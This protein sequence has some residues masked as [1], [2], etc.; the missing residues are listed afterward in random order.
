M[1]SR[2]R[3]AVIIGAIVGASIL[4]FCG[5]MIFTLAVIMPARRERGLAPPGTFEPTVEPSPSSAIVSSPW[6][7]P[8]GPSPT[9]TYAIL[10]LTPTQP[11]PSP[12]LEPAVASS[13]AQSPSPAPSPTPT[14]GGL[15]FYYVEGSRIEELQCTRP[16]LQGW[17]K[18][19][20]G[21]PLNG[22]VVRW[23]YW[24]ITEF[25]ISGDPQKLWQ[26]GEF[27]FTYFGED[28]HRETD[29]V[30]QIVKSIEDPD[31]LSEPLVIHYA[32][33]VE[34]GQ[35]TNIVFKRR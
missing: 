1:K 28:P 16:Y 19:P 4:A 10:I 27:K 20:A 9:P 11:G 32:G 7:T 14:A 30:L 3:V 29:F 18:D 6:A 5:G 34:M 22:A 26:P 13:P 35:I 23:R 2:S 33:C 12:T 25:A 24:N 21:S 31:P 8:Q 17:V 15:P